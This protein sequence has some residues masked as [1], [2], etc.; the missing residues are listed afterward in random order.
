MPQSV[1]AV[2][3]HSADRWGHGGVTGRLH[4]R[5]NRRAGLSS[6]SGSKGAAAHPPPCRAGAATALLGVR[7][8]EGG[9]GFPVRLL[10]LLLLLLVP[11]GLT[12]PARQ[13][14]K[15]TAAME[16]FE[17]GLSQQT[18]TGIWAERRLRTKAWVSPLRQGLRGKEMRTIQVRRR[19]VQEH[20]LSSG[21]ST[22]WLG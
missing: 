19:K 13:W 12:A 2:G 15:S 10:M 1:V 22:K 18:E 16:W 9:G 5:G 17:N 21:H 11:T 20:P 14:T 8:C 4:G 7:V 6:I 3:T